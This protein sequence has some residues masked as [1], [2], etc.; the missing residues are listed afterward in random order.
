MR[1]AK[2]YDP[3]FQYEDEYIPLL[4]FKEGSKNL[5]CSEQTR[6]TVTYDKIMALV[7]A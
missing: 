4:L 6:N 3:I 7:E 2:L 1:R 5:I